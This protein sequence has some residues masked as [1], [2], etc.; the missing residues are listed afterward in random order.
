MII[1]IPGIGQKQ[2]DNI[3][4]DYNGTIAK[5]GVVY[6]KVMPLFKA[7][8]AHFNLYVLTADTHGSA[9]ANLKNTNTNLHILNSQNHTQEKADFVKN[10]GNVLAIGNGCNDAMMLKMA[11][12]GICV[13]NEEGACVHSILNADIL[14]NSIIDACDLILKPKRL[15]ATLRK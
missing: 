1:E 8:S 10:L 9:K 4:F 13:A 5:D 2:I 6:E 14:C 7:L 15:I 12:I 11:Q 3:V